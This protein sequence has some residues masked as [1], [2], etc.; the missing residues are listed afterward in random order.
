MKIKNK[1]HKG[2]TKKLNDED[3]E[4]KFEEEIVEV[5]RLSLYIAGYVRTIMIG[6]KT[7]F[8]T[9]EIL[10]KTFRLKDCEDYKQV[11]IKK[12]V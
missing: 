6:L 2:N 4:T 7:Q 10:A 8:K 5:M 12:S 11:F 3:E 1:D 9:E